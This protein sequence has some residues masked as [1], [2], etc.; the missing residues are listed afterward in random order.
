MSLARGLVL[1]PHLHATGRAHVVPSLLHPSTATV[2]PCAAHIALLVKVC[3]IQQRCFELQNIVFLFERLGYRKRHSIQYSIPQLVACYGT[4]IIRRAIDEVTRITFIF[5][6]YDW[7]NPTLHWIGNDSR[8]SIR[9]NIVGGRLFPARQR[10][11][12]DWLNSTH[13]A[14]DPDHVEIGFHLKC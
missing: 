12:R 8:E 2:L 13:S 1:S 9:L 14:R 3:C 4:R 7:R 11:A 6:R 10:N 5:R